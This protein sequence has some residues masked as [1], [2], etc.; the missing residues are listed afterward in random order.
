MTKA[1]LIDVVAKK[2]DCTKKLAGEVIE[3][4]TEAVQGADKVV[5]QG[6]GTFEYKT[7]P[8]RKGRN[9]QTG[10]EIQI[11]ASKYLHFKASSKQK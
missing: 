7:R 9:P 5:M 4:F 11:A 6:F 3:A 10:K 2:V 8:A 1:E